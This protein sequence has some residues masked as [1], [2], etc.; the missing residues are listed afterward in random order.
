MHRE[1]L[2]IPWQQ[3]ADSGTVTLSK[4]V[5]IAKSILAFY[6]NTLGLPNFMPCLPFPPHQSRH[7]KDRSQRHQGA[8][9]LA[10]VDL[11]LS[12]QDKTANDA[13]GPPGCVRAA[14]GAAELHGGSH[15]V[16]RKM[17]YKWCGYCLPLWR[18][19]LTSPERSTYAKKRICKRT[20]SY[21]RTL[22]NKLCI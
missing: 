7:C 14:S 15:V 13:S 3:N 16:S 10:A 9:S 21:T 20:R 6:L 11:W 22:P 2:H 18:P 19:R 4:T 8:Q 5:E 1:L 12:R 17:I